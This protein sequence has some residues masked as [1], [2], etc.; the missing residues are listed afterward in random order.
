MEQVID[1]SAKSSTVSKFKLPGVKRVIAVASGKGGVGKSTVATNLALALAAEGNRVGLLDAD[2]YGPSQGLMMGVPDGTKPN[3]ANDLLQPIIAHGLQCMSMSFVASDRTPA[4]WR[5]PMA[6]GALQQLLTQT[7]WQ[8]VD[9][10]VVDMPPGTGDIQLTMAQNVPLAG[11]V[12]V[13]T[14]Q[15]IALLDARKGIEMFRKVAVPL[16]GIVENMSTHTCSECGHQEAIFGEGGGDAIA[17][18]YDLNVL[19]RLP[20]SMAIRMQSDGGQ[21]PLIADPQ[22]PV[23]LQFREMARTIM[24]SLEA[25]NN[26][27]PV[28]QILE[29]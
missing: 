10:L 25:A 17:A 27:G 21:P 12:I 16:L 22:G 1:S 5:G 8:A 4:V 19:A 3:V 23:S 26:T 15:D 14:P 6:S 9:V 29:D 24:A 13:T 11:A 28:I 20:L 7:E 2:I 18:E